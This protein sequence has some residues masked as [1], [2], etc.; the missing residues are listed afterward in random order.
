MKNE[1]NVRNVSSHINFTKCCLAKP[2][3]LSAGP[4]GV[5]FKEVH[6]ANFQTGPTPH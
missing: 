2:W 6:A 1:Q 5:L 4:G 3:D